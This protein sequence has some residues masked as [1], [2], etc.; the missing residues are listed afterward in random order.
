MYICVPLGVCNGR[1]VCGK[2]LSYHLN[3]V[4]CTISWSE[5][6]KQIHLQLHVW[7]HKHTGVYVMYTYSNTLWGCCIITGLVPLQTVSLYI[8]IKPVTFCF[9]SV[10]Q[11]VGWKSIFTNLRRNTERDRETNR[12]DWLNY[13]SIADREDSYVRLPQL[14]S[15]R[16]LVWNSNSWGSPETIWHTYFACWHYM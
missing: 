5:I 6:K 1:C 10:L 11:I 12:E 2:C 4:I 14:H 7:L 3:G 9:S 16:G 15:V 8:K 13:Y